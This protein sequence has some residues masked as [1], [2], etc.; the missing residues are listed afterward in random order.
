[1]SLYELPSF[2]KNNQNIPCTKKGMIWTKLNTI[3][4]TA[5]NQLR[6]AR[7]GNAVGY[8][9]YIV[10]DNADSTF[11]FNFVNCD[12]STARAPEDDIVTELKARTTTRTRA[13]RENVPKFRIIHLFICDQLQC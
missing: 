13:D 11:F 10:D 2:I 7:A 9:S 3:T 12:S 5:G 4:A 1:M 8:I 6:C